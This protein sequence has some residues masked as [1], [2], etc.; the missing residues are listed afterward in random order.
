MEYYLIYHMQLKVPKL[1]ISNSQ[2]YKTIII[3][4]TFFLVAN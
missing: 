1:Y 2:I 3:I 4:M